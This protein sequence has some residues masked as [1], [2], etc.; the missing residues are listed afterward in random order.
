MFR[1]YHGQLKRTMSMIQDLVKLCSTDDLIE[2]DTLT[3]VE[4]LNE[5]MMTPDGGYNVAEALSLASIVHTDLM[6]TNTKNSS[7]TTQCFYPPPAK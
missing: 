3:T 6:K 4:L 1:A 7:T 2:S 5:R